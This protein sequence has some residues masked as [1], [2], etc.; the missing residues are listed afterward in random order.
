MTLNTFKQKRLAMRVA[1]I[2][3]RYKEIDDRFDQELKVEEV[4][5][6]SIELADRFLEV[7]RLCS[8]YGFP[9][10][11]AETFTAVCI[12]LERKITT[13]ESEKELNEYANY[14][15]TNFKTLAHNIGVL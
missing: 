4:K 2:L 3:K 15:L 7:I 8:K 5:T 12:D 10:E 13:T 6:L 1:P 9:K 14:L 11:K